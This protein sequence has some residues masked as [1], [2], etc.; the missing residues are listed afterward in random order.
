MALGSDSNRRPAAWTGSPAPAVDRMALVGDWC[1][2]VAAHQVT[3][4]RVK[5][6]KALVVQIGRA[7][8][9]IQ[10][11]VPER[12]ALIDVADAGTDTLL[13]E[14]FPEGGRLRAARAADHLIN[15]ER[16]D[17]DIGSQVGDRVSGIAHQL[18]NG[19]GEANRDDV[20][21]AEHRGGAPLGLAP[22][23]P[24]SVEVP[25]T[26]HPHV[27]MKRQ[28]SF[29]LHDEVFAVGFDRL[30]PSAFQSPE[31]CRTGVSDDLAADLAP[32]GGCR[33]PDRVAFRQARAAALARA[34]RLSVSC[35]TRLRAACPP[36][37]SP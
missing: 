34:P 28:P 19:R 37:A 25:G 23:L 3:D 36:A 8:P 4:R 20:V 10:A 21:E 2:Q 13:E 14:Q 31:R 22:A 35:R 7:H 11:V 1:H 33:S 6:A 26:G 24:N 17:Q 29:E 5:P 32:Q 16:I 18:H 9:W 12:L 30:D 27:R 15:V